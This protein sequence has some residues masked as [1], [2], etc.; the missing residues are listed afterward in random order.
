MP[1]YCSIVVYAAHVSFTVLLLKLMQWQRVT[2]SYTIP[3]TD[4]HDREQIWERRE[5][6]EGDVDNVH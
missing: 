3:F 4:L 5:G 2:L 1:E 6:G